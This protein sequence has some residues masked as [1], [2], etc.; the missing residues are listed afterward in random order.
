M[1]EWRK[2]HKNIS[3]SKRLGALKSHVPRLLYTW[4]IPW[5][6]CEGRCTADPDLIKGKVFTKVKMITLSDIEKAL[7][8]LHDAELIQVYTANGESYLQYEQ[9]QFE[10]HQNI[11]RKEDGT[12]RKE[13]PT[14]IPDPPSREYSGVTPEYSGVSREYSGVTPPRLDKIRL[15]KIREEESPADTPSPSPILSIKKKA[16]IKAWNNL[17]DKHGLKHLISIAVGST[18]ETHFIAR[19]KEELFDIQKIMDAADKMDFCFGN[20]DRNWKISFDWIIKNTGNYIQILEEKY[21]NDDQKKRE[22]NMEGIDNE[23]Y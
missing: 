4:L 20:N 7:N 9:P 15:D 11:G 18:R 3:D 1:P 13:A 2:I 21:L 22:F 12:P 17:A 10:E 5:T 8:A 6:D 16:A 14:K 19:I 23:P